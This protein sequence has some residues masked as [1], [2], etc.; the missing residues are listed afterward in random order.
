MALTP[1]ERLEK[2]AQYIEDWGNAVRQDWSFFDGRTAKHQMQDIADFLRSDKD[3]DPLAGTVCRK[4]NF[5][6]HW[7]EWEIEETNFYHP[8]SDCE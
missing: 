4:G 2:G 6:A 1:Q 7:Q 8:G 3:Y 5:G